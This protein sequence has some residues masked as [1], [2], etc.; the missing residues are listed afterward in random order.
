MIYQVSPR[1][2]TLSA[3]PLHALFFALLALP[4]YT[5]VFGTFV[6]SLLAEGTELAELGSQT[7]WIF[8]IL[9][10]AVIF[11]HV[12]LW[13]ER[14]GAGPFAG[15]MKARA[16]WLLA[17]ILFTPVLHFVVSASAFYVLGSGDGSDVI[18][19]ETAREML[20]GDSAG[21]LMFF[22]LVI[23]APL[24]EEVTIRGVALGCLLGRGVPTLAA[25]I[26]QA[27]A[28]TLL[29]MQYTLAGLVPVFILGLFI[30]WLR[31]ASKSIL[32]PIAAHAAVNMQA[33]AVLVLVANEAV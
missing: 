12:T 26:L 7:L 24:V 11:I 14:V 19:D 23:L 29:H 9:I 18:R 17:A 5:V 33:F 10:Q 28:F 6:F 13:A 2:Q 16:S 32:V 20:S 15:Q 30:G 22:S 27:A 4:V 1:D 25:I 8:Q 21:L 31:V 3:H